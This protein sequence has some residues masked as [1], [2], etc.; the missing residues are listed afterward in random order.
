MQQLAVMFQRSGSNAFIV[1]DSEQILAQAPLWSVLLVIAAVATAL[2]RRQ[3][4][5]D[6]SRGT[7][8]V[9][10]RETPDGIDV[11]G[12]PSH[13]AVVESSHDHRCAMSFA[14]LALCT[15]G[16]ITIEGAEYI[17]TSYP[18]FRRDLGALGARLEADG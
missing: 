6:H 4:A 11:R 5:D 17:D 16:G 15:D 18:D 9:E 3:P 13:H 8:G 10:V 1:Q 2:L 12:G 7:V 14:V